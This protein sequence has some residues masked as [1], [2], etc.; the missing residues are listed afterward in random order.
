MNPSLSEFHYPTL[1]YDDYCIVCS[2]FAKFISHISNQQIKILGHYNSVES[3]KLKDLIFINY[4]GDPAKMFWI[5]TRDG[6]FGSRHGLMVLIKE[7]IKINLRL[8]N[9]G[10]V[11]P[12]TVTHGNDN[13]LICKDSIQSNSC[14]GCKND[15]IG[16]M[17]RILYLFRN[18]GFVK[19]C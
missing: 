9:Y 5:I 3:K 14:T 2:H 1:I 12:P 16:I 13:I 4:T 18:S 8:V 7:L 6:A 11:D 19:C 15:L 17:K 10:R